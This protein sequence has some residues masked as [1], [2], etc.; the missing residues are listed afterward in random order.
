MTLRTVLLWLLVACLAVPAGAQDEG[1][2]SVALRVTARRPGARVMVDRGAQDGLLEGDVVVFQPRTGRPVTGHVLR[3]EE[4]AALVLLAETIDL[5]PGTRGDARVPLAR[6][7]PLPPPEAVADEPQELPAQPVE[8]IEPAPDH[9]AWENGD[10]EW[11]PDLPLLARVRV[12]RPEDRESRVTGFTYLSADQILTT[13]SDRSDGFYRFGT[14]LLYENPFGRGGEL[15]FDAELNYRY[16]DVP[17]QGDEDEVHLRLDRLSYAWGGTRWS[18]QRWEAGRFLHHVMPELGVVDGAEWSQRFDDGDRVGASVGY[19]PEPNQDYETGK[20]FQLS[21]FYE[22]VADRSE[23]L[24]AAGA[25]QKSWHNGAADRDLFVGRV[26]YLPAEGWHVNATTWIDVYTSGDDAKGS[27]VE[28]TQAVASVGKRWESGDGLNLTYNRI[29]FPEIDR[30]EFTPVGAN[31][32]ADDHN[33]RLALSGWTWIGEEERL[34]GVIAGWTD[35]DDSGGDGEMGLEVF[36]LFADGV[37]ADVTVFGTLGRFESAVGARLTFTRA[38]D[39]GSWDLMYEI[40]NHDQQG[41]DDTNDDILQ[42]RL[43][44]SCDLNSLSGWGLSLY[45]EGVTWEDETGLLAGFYLRKSF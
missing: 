2:A 39:L 16:T 34:H 20:D 7:G 22:W 41:F 33:D 25:Y 30:F 13:E 4:R 10:E 11:S 35:E 18:S 31:Q 15:S 21:V 14:D 44:G 42:H 1:V 37:S 38:V 19:L 9:P 27:G 24:T 6:L 32:L 23:T 40:A 17:D 5:P 12:L 3:L 45:A 26:Q 28:L 43:R 36:D 29:L 8:P